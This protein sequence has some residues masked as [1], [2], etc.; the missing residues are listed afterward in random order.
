MLRF[1]G[2]ALPSNT[3][4]DVTGP[5]VLGEGSSFDVAIIAGR[6]RMLGDKFNEELE[7]P[8]R[9][10]IAESV[11]GQVSF[12]LPSVCC[13]FLLQTPFSYHSSSGVTG[14]VLG[15]IW[16]LLFIQEDTAGILRWP[17]L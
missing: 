13:F 10:V 6:L 16:G 4:T 15:K 3:V 7:A 2:P 8:A 14:S 12:P 17:I 5:S 9:S 1:L 11:R